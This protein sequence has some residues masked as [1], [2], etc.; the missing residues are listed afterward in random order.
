MPTSSISP[1]Q[2]MF[3]SA[4]NPPPAAATTSYNFANG[5]SADVSNGQVIGKNTDF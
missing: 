3:N 2:S 4:G 1:A 5:S